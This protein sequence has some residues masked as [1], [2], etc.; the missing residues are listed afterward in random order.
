M[1][2]ATTPPWPAAR[3][4]CGAGQELA[5]GIAPNLFFIANNWFIL[6]AP[7]VSLTTGNAQKSNRVGSGNCVSKG[8]EG[9]Q[10]GLPSGAT[11]VP[12]REPARSQ[13]R[14]RSLRRRG[15]GLAGHVRLNL[16]P[17][18]AQAVIVRLVSVSVGKPAGICQ[19]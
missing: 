8:E 3:I 17:R 4:Q 9:T 13:V 2:S 12:N 15:L 1:K 6:H 7:I 16:A 19:P 18:L 11:V 14:M 5:G 10:W